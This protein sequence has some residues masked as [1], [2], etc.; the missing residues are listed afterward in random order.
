MT[1][2]TDTLPL[3]RRMKRKAACEFLRERLGCGVSMST[4]RRW[5]IGYVVIGR[6]ASYLESDLETFA[7][8]RLESAPYC[9]PLP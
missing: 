9:M 6:D 5:P 4:I 1:D 3:R 2:T 8:R 7:R